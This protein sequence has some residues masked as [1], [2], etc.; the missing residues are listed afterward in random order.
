VAI[1]DRYTMDPMVGDPD[2][3]RPDSRWAILVDPGSAAGRVDSL[4][5][6][7]EAI[8]PGDRIPLHS[9][10]VDE[11]VLYRSGAARVTL[12]DE[13]AD[14]GAG[15]VVYIPAGTPHATRNPGPAP[16]E[17]FAVYPSTRIDITYLERNAAPGTEGATA[18]SP[19]AIDLRTGSV[20][21]MGDGASAD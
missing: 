11:V 8:A 10:S 19:S 20:E 6:L 4:G 5:G 18:Q 17:L 16:V 7:V 14:V 3:H 9:H 12:G 2:D 13:E 1:V 21:P 15:A